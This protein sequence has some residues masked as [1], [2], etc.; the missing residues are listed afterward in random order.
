MGGAIRST[1]VVLL[2]PSG[3]D[4][5]FRF[6]GG[7]TFSLFSAMKTLSLLTSATSVVWELRFK[8]DRFAL[9]LLTS[10]DFCAADNRAVCS[11]FTAARC[12]ERVAA[13]T[14][15]VWA[16]IWRERIALFGLLFTISAMMV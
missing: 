7:F 15:E 16:I 9:L 3:G 2:D 4:L 1:L 5:L 8:W 13:A 12:L 11:L 10:K 6:A 14:V